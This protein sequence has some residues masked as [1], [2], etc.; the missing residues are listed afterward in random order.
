[1]FRKHTF[2]IFIIVFLWTGFVQ[3]KDCKSYLVKV[4]S[5]QQ[6]SMYL[7]QM[8]RGSLN[9]SRTK[10][11]FKR[12]LTPKD[13]WFFQIPFI[14]TRNYKRAGEYIL[15]HHNVLPLNLQTA[16]FLNK[17]LTQDLVPVDI[18]GDPN[19]RLN[20]EAINEAA[21]FNLGVPT[22][23]YDWLESIEAKNLGEVDPIALAE[24]VHNH[25]SALDSFPDGNGRLARLFADLVLLKAGLAPAQ[26]TSLGDY[27]IRGNPRSKASRSARKQYFNDAMAKN[28]Q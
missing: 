11:Q 27:F 7:N 17:L 15:D 18:I 13:I 9:L 14:A 20:S 3:A 16:V 6:K 21:P 4:L 2:F 10:V 25:I 22:G 19:Y 1:M 24:I 5:S 8:L 28:Y 23:F 26:Y 12:S